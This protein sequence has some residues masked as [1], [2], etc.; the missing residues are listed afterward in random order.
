MALALKSALKSGIKSAIKSGAGSPPPP[1]PPIYAPLATKIGTGGYLKSSQLGVSDTGFGIISLDIKCIVGSQTN[2]NTT[3]FYNTYLRDVISNIFTLFQ[4]EGVPGFNLAVD[5]SGGI[6]GSL[7]VNFADNSGNPL[8]GT[9]K[10]IIQTIP[11]FFLDKNGAFGN[12]TIIFSLATSGS[13]HIYTYWNGVLVQ[14]DG[15]AEYNNGWNV[16]PSPIVGTFT[17]YIIANTAG[18]GIGQCGATIQIGNATFDISRFLIDTATLD[19]AALG[20]SAATAL[21]AKIWDP[22]SNKPV[23][24]GTGGINLFGTQLAVYHV[25][26][27]ANFPTELGSSGATWTKVAAVNP[28]GPAIIWDAPVGPG[29]PQDTRPY[30]LWNVGENPGALPGTNTTIQ[31]KNLNC[32]IALNDFII[33]LAFGTNNSGTAAGMA[34]TIG[35]NFTV[36]TATG[37]SLPVVNDD[38]NGRPSCLAIWTKKAEVGDVTAQG[39]N[40]TNAPIITWAVGPTRNSYYKIINFGQISGIDVMDAAIAAA[41]SASHLI[42]LSNPG[43]ATTVL[44]LLLSI[45]ALYG[46][47]DYTAT[48]GTITLPTGQRAIDATLAGTSSTSTL[49][50]SAEPISALGAVGTRT[51][52][53]PGYSSAFSAG[54]VSTLSIVLK[55]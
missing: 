50:I 2:P 40:W 48:T 27:A 52:N 5:N 41:G 4:S 20:Q 30:D 45:F 44:G 13:R 49:C 6:I 35:D 36:P 22:V 43:N 54:R 8:L 12:L 39:A 31:T 11:G 7:K 16:T 47:P 38:G 21:A 42:T 55:P 33:I 46:M 51:A 34:P 25:G 32:P 15:F 37:V 18:F 26:N 10:A 23:D 1:P 9:N 17:P 3:G 53:A 14:A 29:G 28:P 19:V 24:L